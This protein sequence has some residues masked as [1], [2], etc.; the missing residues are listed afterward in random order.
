MVDNVE[1]D[2]MAEESGNEMERVR[3]GLTSCFEQ[4]Q[5]EAEAIEVSALSRPGAGN[6]NETLLFD[7]RSKR[8]GVWSTQPLV[9]RLAPTK[10]PQVFP[11]YD[12]SLQYRVMEI[13]GKTEVPVPRLFGYEASPDLL[14][15]PFYVMRRV[16]GRAPL[17]NP[18]YHAQGWLAESTAEEQAAIWDSGLQEVARINNLDCEA[19]GFGFL[20]EPERGATP[21][22]QHLDFYREFFAWILEGG[23]HPL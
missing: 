15:A 11:T 14:G 9:A 21:L 13:L 3:A 17:E 6:S 5:P 7:L 4:R 18:P 10:G 2:R 16:D 23:S 8:D 20:D 1:V 19:L 12:L 22:D